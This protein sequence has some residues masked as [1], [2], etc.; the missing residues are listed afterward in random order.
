[1]HAKDV[2]KKTV[3]AEDVEE[4]GVEMGEER[5]VMLESRMLPRA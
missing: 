2:K 5:A 1:M 4:R 3:N